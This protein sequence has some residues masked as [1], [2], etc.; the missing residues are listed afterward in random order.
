MAKHRV[1]QGLPALPLPSSVPQLSDVAANLLT[2]ASELLDPAPG[3]AVL[4]PGNE[5]SWDVPDGG[6]LWVR[7][8]SQLP[9]GEVRCPTFTRA[10]LGLGVLRCVAT[11]DNDG[12]PPKWA[13]RTEDA[14]QCWADSAVLFEAVQNLPKEFVAAGPQWLALGPEGG[15]AG[16]EWTIP[17]NLAA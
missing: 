16:G 7:V 8:I 15:V 11:M 13:E 10:N 5:V 3:A 12:G 4:W 1:N 17:V 14:L 6:L 2:F 9:Q